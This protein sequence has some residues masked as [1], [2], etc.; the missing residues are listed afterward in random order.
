M[1]R[2]DR[3]ETYVALKL[4]IDNWRWAGVPFYLRTGKRLTAR[5]TEIAIHFKPAPQALFR[6]TPVDELAANGLVLQIQ[7]DEG[8]CLHFGAKARAR[9]WRSTAWHGF[10]LRRL[11]QAAARRLRDPALRLPHRRPDPVPARRQVE[12]GWAA[13]QPF[14]D[15]WAN[16]TAGGRAQLRRRQRRARRRRRAAGA[17]RPRLASHPLT[18][19]APPQILVL[20]DPRTLAAAAA[21]WIAA[22]I[23]ATAIF[24]AL[25]FRA[26]ARRGCSTTNCLPCFATPSNG[27][28]SNC[29]GATSASFRT[30]TSAAITAWRGRPCFRRRRC[31]SIT[32]TRFRRKANR[33]PPHAATRSQLKELWR[34]TL[35][36]AQPLFH[37][38]LLGLGEDGHKRRCSRAAAART[39]KDWVRSQQAQRAA[40]HPHLPR[41]R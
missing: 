24:I 25:P 35:S 9:R 21:E 33:K 2:T 20:P 18:M 40:H 30:P 26:A 6:D 27:A 37:L 8:I 10:P 41:H 15:A 11:V 1:S 23:A 3:T 39:K 28:A 5:G 22:R 13:V 38:V 34:G 4:K 36:P 16:R 12:A 7:P 19:A 14:L 31:S 32:S 29:S 17:R